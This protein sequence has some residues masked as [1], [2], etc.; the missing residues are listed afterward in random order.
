M[1]SNTILQELS[2]IEADNFNKTIDDECLQRKI[3]WHFS[4]PRSAHFNGL[5]E[6]AVKSTKF[7]LYRALKDATPTF[8]EV[9]T[10]LCQIESILNSRPLCELSADPNDSTAITPAHF[11]NIAATRPIPDQDFSEFKANQLKR[12]QLVQKISQNFWKKWRNEYLNQLQIRAKWNTKKQEMQLGDLVMLKEANLPPN[13]WPLG[14]IVEKHPGKDGIT[15]VVSVKT[16]KN[17]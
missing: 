1:A 11:L 16:P 17:T 12:W 9:T 13:S 2:A 5:V 6:A 7:H 15:R 3:T 8:E 14:R 4:P 10:L